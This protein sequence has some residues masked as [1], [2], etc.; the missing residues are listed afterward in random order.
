[1]KLLVAVLVLAGC[2]HVLRASAGPA[3]R[4]GTFGAQASVEAGTHLFATPGMHS[5]IGL[6]G[7]GGF[8]GDDAEMLLAIT[9]SLDLGVGFPHELALRRKRGAA[10]IGKAWRVA[11]A[12]G[13]TKSPH[14]PSR[15]SGMFRHHAAFGHGFIRPAGP[16]DP[17]YEC[18]KIPMDLVHG[19][20]ELS[21]TTPLDDEPTTM[22]AQAYLQWSRVPEFDPRFG[23][24]PWPSMKR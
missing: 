20:V 1:M 18:R 2:G 11:S 9:S 24:D 3:A 19:G 23:W 8:I 13:T 14:R 16:C 6:R 5:S 15:G 12:F 4:D 22:A 21:F 10:G 17:Y 7:Q